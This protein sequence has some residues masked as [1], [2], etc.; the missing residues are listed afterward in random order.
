MTLALS[1]IVTNWKRQKYL[2]AILEQLAGQSYPKDRYE[3]IIIDDDT[4]NKEEVYK[5]VKD[6]VH[7]YENIKIRFF[8]THKQIT[9]NPALRYNIGIRKASNEIIL[10][11]ESD[12]LQIGEYL[13]RVNMNHQKQGNIFLSPILY[14]LHD[15]GSR[16][17]TPFRGPLVDL[18]GSIRK[19][20]FFKVK[21][22]DETYQ[23]W[24]GL[25]NRL[26]DRLKLINVKCHKDPELEVLHKGWQ[27]NEG[28]P[29]PK[30]GRA[31]AAHKYPGTGRRDDEWGTID[32]L[33][34]ITF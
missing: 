20:H 18:G 15:D 23:G 27:K 4:P 29:F 30:E 3:V 32:T 5:I 16:S 21:G 8:E 33:E 11:N 26:Q 22:C 7:K 25:E 1:I 24:G 19:E 14:D 6:L 10:L 9:H 13:Q 12:T 28:V 2:P 34:E 31:D 17:S